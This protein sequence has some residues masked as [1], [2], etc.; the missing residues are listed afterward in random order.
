MEPHKIGRS[1]TRLRHL[2]KMLEENSN[3]LASMEKDLATE[4][5]HRRRQSLTNQI[6]QIKA[7]IKA[8]E[9][10]V[11]ELESTITN[12]SVSTTTIMPS[13]RLEVSFKTSGIVSILGDRLY[14][15]PLVFVRENI[16]NAVD[17]TRLR[18]ARSN[19]PVKSLPISIEI[20]E[21]SFAVTDRGLGMTIDH[22]KEFYWS[23]GSTSKNTDE[24]RS[25]RCIGEFG[26]GGFA[27]FGMSSDVEVTTAVD[28]QSGN[29]TAIT[30]EQLFRDERELDV[31]CDSDFWGP[32][33]RVRCTP[34]DG[35]FPVDEMIEFA[36]E[37]AK[38]LPE[39]LLINGVQ[40]ERVDYDELPGDGGD[41]VTL[42]FGKGPL[43]GSVVGR[44]FT[45]STRVA[46][47]PDIV[48]FRDEEHHVRG[49]VEV[50]REPLR[51]LKHDF[52]ITEA[53]IKGRRLGGRLDLPFLRPTANRQGLEQVSSRKLQLLH[54]AITTELVS[55]IAES[56]DL[57]DTYW[58]EGFRDFVAQ[59]DKHSVYL[60]Y[61][62][63]PLM[64]GGSI[65]LNDLRA[66]ATEIYI[67]RGG[68][69]FRK[70]EFATDIPALD[71]SALDK[72][73][74][75][76]IESDLKKYLTV[77]ERPEFE[78][79]KLVSIECL[80]TED[81]RAIAAIKK[82]LD[83]H[84]YDD[85]PV[86]LMAI[87][88]ANKMTARVLGACFE[89]NVASD[90]FKSFV[91][92]IA[93]SQDERAII[94]AGNFV[95][96]HGKESLSKLRRKVFG[97][98]GVGPLAV[99]KHLPPRLFGQRSAVP[100]IETNTA[101]K[102]NVVRDPGADAES[103]WNGEGHDLIELHD[104]TTGKQRRFL[105]IPEALVEEYDLVAFGSVHLMVLA[106]RFYLLFY[107]DRR[108]VEVRARSV[109]HAASMMSGSPPMLERQTS[110]MSEA[111]GTFV[112]IDEAASIPAKMRWAVVFDTN[113]GG[114]LE[115]G[116]DSSLLDEAM[117]A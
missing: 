20:S 101:S 95:L 65:T 99:E 17:A 24:A 57:M 68:N 62:E 106:D 104:R 5:D 98:G 72:R 93:T 103:C 70:P 37:C 86:Q 84:G 51:L 115:I 41:I 90:T 78:E 2:T 47:S 77:R 88:P 66:S 60:K 8:D 89:V 26:I 81:Q 69:K 114:S 23:V 10:E 55:C 12:H 50:S 48:R 19:I 49:Q 96:D 46:F 32:G 30:R 14:S 76:L 34:K 83:S 100:E 80:A 3:L 59:S 18:S 1:R 91:L 71:L 33:T 44:L 58:S 31:K 45:T 16:Q 105:R 64:G 111:E 9:S 25:A 112:E 4:L 117:A 54:D 75:A 92:Q 102:S 21:D 79:A 38:H 42:Q 63:V 113:A 40:V 53:D 11:D 94:V 39:T 35:Y 97:E 56:V 85:V 109:G 6:T 13:S 28:G 27:N 73:I 116:M 87:Q 107:S 108:L 74:R 61:F 43:A 15:S 67:Y 52:P 36:Q 29:V 7:A 22:L 82:W 110:L